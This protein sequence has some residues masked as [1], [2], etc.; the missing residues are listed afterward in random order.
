MS[1]GLYFMSI[2]FSEEINTKVTQVKEEF[3]IDF[4]ASRAL[5][6]P[7]HIT[8]CPPFKA[9]A[10]V[11]KALQKSLVKFAVKQ[12]RFS[13][14]L[15]GYGAFEPRVI[16]VQPN[17]EPLLRKLYF[18]LKKHLVQYFPFENYH[19]GTGFKPHI[20]VAYR[21]LD[22]KN[23]DKAWHIFNKRS[24]HG[25]QEIKSFFLLRHDG[26]TWKPHSEFPLAVSQN[27]VQASLF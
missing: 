21:D 1:E 2:L 6:N 16:F 8:I 27:V 18:N 10:T 25:V 12:K 14:T 15:D 23:F 4:N 5:R 19:F 22:K 7:A 3:S 20:T 26:N 13:L 11:I 17:E 24:F 9:D